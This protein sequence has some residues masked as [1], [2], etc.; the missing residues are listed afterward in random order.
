MYDVYFV[1]GCEEREQYLNLIR[2]LFACCD[3]YSFIYFK[4]RE[5]EKTSFS[6]KKIQKMLSKYKI[7]SRRA[8][9]WPLTVTS[10]DQG[11]IY[12]F[13]TY[14]IDHSDMEVLSAF[15][16]PNSLWEWDYPESPM[17]L[18]FYRNGRVFFAS[19]AHEQMNELY[20]NSEGDT[21]SAADFES[22]GLKLYHLRKIPE[23]K[24]FL[25]QS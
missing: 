16:L 18:C 22:I 20:L 15:E 9:R 10:N 6:T 19:C 5:N 23:E 25:L 11:H 13:V 14:R 8:S 3:T 4:Y 1:D 17:D 21:L 12:R 2:I 24:L 7:Q